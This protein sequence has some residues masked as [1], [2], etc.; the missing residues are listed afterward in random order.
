LTEKREGT[1][2]KTHRTTKGIF[3]LLKGWT[4]NSQALSD[5]LKD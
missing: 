3:G 1:L 2:K 5:E 4:I